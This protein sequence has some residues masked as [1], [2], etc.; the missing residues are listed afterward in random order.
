MKDNFDKFIFVVFTFLGLFIIVFTTIICLKLSNASIT[1][2]YFKPHE[3]AIWEECMND[4]NMQDV[5]K[6][7][8]FFLYHNYISNNRYI[9]QLCTENKCMDCWYVKINEHI[10]NSEYYFDV[11]TPITFNRSLCEKLA[12]KIIKDNNLT[13]EKTHKEG[14]LEEKCLYHRFFK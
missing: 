1:I 10:Y 14:E 13:W 4:S 12:Q 9:V 8:G 2:K 5:Y 6:P 11:I 3:Y 7:S